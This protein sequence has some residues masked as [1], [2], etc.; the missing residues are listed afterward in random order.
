MHNYVPSHH[1]LG[2]RTHTHLS[3]Y[4]NKQIIKF[5]KNK[6]INKNKEQTNYAYCIYIYTCVWAWVYGKGITWNHQIVKCPRAFRLRRLAQS[7]VPGLGLRHSTCKFSHEVALVKCPPAFRL[8]TLA[9]VSSPVLGSVVLL[10]LIILIL[11]IIILNIIVR[12]MILII[13]ILIINIMIHY[14]PT[15][16]HCLGSQDSCR[17]NGRIL[18][19]KLI[20][21]SQSI[22]QRFPE[23]THKPGLP[24]SDPHLL[25]RLWPTRS[26]PLRTD[27]STPGPWGLG[28]GLELY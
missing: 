14:P 19:G 15:P 16:P 21:I 7:V 5:L 22:S 2:C 23:E 20:A 1:Q 26:R 10:N 6:C 25:L 8:H 3:M 12:N 28:P 11:N 4:Q 27:A 24:G 9:K 18:W 17:D 13:I